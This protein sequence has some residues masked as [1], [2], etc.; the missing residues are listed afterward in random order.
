[1]IKQ[2]TIHIDDQEQDITIGSAKTADSI[3]R[4]DLMITATNLDAPESTKRVAFFLY[5]TCVASVREPAFVKE[6]SLED[7]MQRVDEVDID[8]WMAAA[9][10]CNT[11]WRTAIEALSK[12]GN[13]EAE[14]KTGTFSDGSPELTEAPT[15]ISE[16]SPISTT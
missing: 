6:M 9:Y 5:P 2:I 13:E 10:E 11:H 4:S 8:T 12:V 3:R 14:K 1:M 15:M 16:I 7:F